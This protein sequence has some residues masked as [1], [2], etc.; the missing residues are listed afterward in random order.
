MIVKQS[1]KIALS[2][3]LINSLAFG[4]SN[5][6]TGVQ[7]LGKNIAKSMINKKK[8]KL[9]IIEFSDLNDNVNDLGR[10]LPEKLITELFKLN[11]E[12]FSIIERRQ[13]SKVLKE[14]KLSTTGLID[15]KTMQKV[16]KILG[17]DALVT[18]S[19][20]DL[21]NIIE[22]NAR[23][24]SV[25]T[26]DIIGTASSRIP[27]VG[28]VATLLSQNN[29]KS[30][31]AS[32][33]SSEKSSSTKVVSKSKSLKFSNRYFHILIDKIEKNGDEI[34]LSCN[35]Q[36]RTDKWLRI[37]INQKET[38]I[39][40]E[41]NK[42]WDNMANTL[43]NS[44]NDLDFNPK[45]GKTP[46]LTFIS[47]GVKNGNKFNIVIEFSITNINNYLTKMEPKPVKIVAT[48]NSVKI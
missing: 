21:G 23:I 43:F 6:E 41:K 5:L 48:F 4:A 42:V 18:G 44:K 27:K 25:E 24:I 35:I 13:L 8:K 34:T 30:P 3:L 22:V 2:L 20:T 36:N 40:N 33:S 14:Q 19:I 9:A 17:V 31:T 10:Y 45:E 32:D 28:T 47:D 39:T 7:E 37:N 46:K 1:K 26:G 38:T 12:G 29:Q 15:S 11:S 16:G